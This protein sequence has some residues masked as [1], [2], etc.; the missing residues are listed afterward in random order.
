[1]IFTVESAN[2][3]QNFGNAAFAMQVGLEHDGDVA[4][5][6]FLLALCS[7]LLLLLSVALF[8]LL[9]NRKGIRINKIESETNGENGRRGYL[10]HCGRINMFFLNFALV[11]KSENL[12]TQVGVW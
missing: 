12:E 7:V 4:A 2:A 3:L 8:V 5:A 1:M 11:L 10:T 9:Q 6:L